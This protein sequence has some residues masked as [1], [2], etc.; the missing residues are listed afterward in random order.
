MLVGT[1]SL[2]SP[3]VREPLVKMLCHRGPVRGLSVDSNGR[4]MATAGSDRRVRIW[5]LRQYKELS[6]IQLA[7]EGGLS[8]SQRGLLAAAVGT[9]AQ[10]FVIIL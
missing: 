7:A 9:S 5:D 8:F 3:N 4:L 6:A 2:W 10:V 1:V